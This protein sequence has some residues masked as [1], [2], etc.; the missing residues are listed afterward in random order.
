M[1]SRGFSG[2]V[3]AAK[4]LK[5]KFNGTTV[6]V[7]K[8]IKAFEAA[9]DAL[10]SKLAAKAKV[11]I[12]QYI[13]L[14]N[15]CGTFLDLTDLAYRGNPH[16]CPENNDSMHASGRIGEG[17]A[18]GKRRLSSF[19]AYPDGSVIFSDPA[20]KPFNKG[21]DEVTAS[22]PQAAGSLDIQENEWQ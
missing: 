7:D 10:P 4:A 17:S 11:G 18:N 5:W 19:H 1:T 22:R 2:S 21:S 14:L 20:L 16:E 13:P 9:V 8:Y 6:P 15:L 3:R 12:I